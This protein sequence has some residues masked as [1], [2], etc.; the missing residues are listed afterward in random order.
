MLDILAGVL[1]PDEGVF[2]GFTPFQNT[3]DNN[4]NKIEISSMG[5]IIFPK[6]ITKDRLELAKFYISVSKFL[7][8]RFD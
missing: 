3:L 6:K 2:L 1:T 4:E 7:S 5:E 8:K